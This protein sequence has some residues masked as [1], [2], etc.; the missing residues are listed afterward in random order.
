[1]S[2]RHNYRETLK[3]KFGKINQLFAPRQ[4]HPKAAL[5]A[6]LRHCG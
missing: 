4:T 2:A 6:A 1:L 3:R 5:F